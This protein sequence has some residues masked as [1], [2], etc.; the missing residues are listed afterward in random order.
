VDQA[1]DIVRHGNTFTFIVPRGRFPQF[2]FATGNGSTVAHFFSAG[3]AS[4]IPMKVTI[5]DGFIVA[6]SYPHGLPGSGVYL[7]HQATWR[8]SDFGSAPPIVAPKVSR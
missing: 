6:I 2:A 7:L 4:N 5:S 3:P 1:T 8:L